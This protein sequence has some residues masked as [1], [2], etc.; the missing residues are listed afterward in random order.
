MMNDERVVVRPCSL[1]PVL[2]FLFFLPSSFSFQERGEKE[3]TKEEQGT[4]NREQRTG[5]SLHEPFGS[6]TKYENDAGA[7]IFEAEMMR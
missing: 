3:R 7:S 5:N 2:C 1:F 4:K 6:P